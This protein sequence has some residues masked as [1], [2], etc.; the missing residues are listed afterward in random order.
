VYRVRYPFWAAQILVEL[1]SGGMLTK[2]VLL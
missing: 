2:K 1:H